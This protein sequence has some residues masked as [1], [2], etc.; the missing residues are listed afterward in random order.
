MKILALM[1]EKAV[2]TEMFPNNMNRLT[3]FGF[4]VLGSF[5]SPDFNGPL[6]FVNKFANARCFSRGVFFSTFFSKIFTN[7]TNP[8]ELIAFY[9]KFKCTSVVRKDFPNFQINKN[10]K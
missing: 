4:S 8:L 10:K 2:L 7:Y 5:G 6:E 3:N 9:L 1:M